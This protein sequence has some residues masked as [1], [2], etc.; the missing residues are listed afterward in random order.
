MAQLFLLAP[1]CG[2]I[3][4]IFSLTNFYYIFFSASGFLLQEE[5]KIK[6]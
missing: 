2:Y 5:K 3:R 6:F 4:L 1:L